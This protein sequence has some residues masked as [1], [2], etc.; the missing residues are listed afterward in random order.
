MNS[1][2]MLSF[3]ANDFS[4]TNIVRFEGD[5][6]GHG[7]RGYGGRDGG[8]RPRQAVRSDPERTVFI[9]N[10]P[11]DATQDDM[12]KLFGEYGHIISTRLL[13][14]RPDL[15]GKCFLEFEEK[16]MAQKAI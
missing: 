6:E 14:R 13:N 2:N 3:Q 4:K 12:E 15:P 8:S 7:D 1:Y 16:D 5:G 10:V 11:N 9:D